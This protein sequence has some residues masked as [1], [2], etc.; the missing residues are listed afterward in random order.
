MNVL[1]NSLANQASYNYNASLYNFFGLKM[2]QHQAFLYHFNAFLNSVKFNNIIEIGA[3]HGGLT[4]LLDLKAKIEGLQFYSFDTSSYRWHDRQ[5]KD[6]GTALVIG[7]VMA[8]HSAS[9]VE[10]LL[11]TDGRSLLLCD[12]DAKSVEFNR[13]VPF[14]KPGDFVMVHDFAQ[15]EERGKKNEEDSTW[16]WV[17]C[18]MADIQETCDKHGIVRITDFEQFVWF[19]GMKK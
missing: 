5:L 16:R 3:G 18:K 4:Y 19:M 13:F 2:Q 12:A 6:L 11:K 17:H 1:L 10:H 8:Q 7:D 9:I 14:M 15:D